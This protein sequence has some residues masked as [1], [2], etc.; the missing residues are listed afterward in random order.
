MNTKPI[1]HHLKI[2]LLH[3]NGDIE[4]VPYADILYITYDKPYTTFCYMENRKERKCVLELSLTYL[5]QNLPEIFFR[6][7]PGVILNLCH[8]RKHKHVEKVIVM[9]NGKEF[10]MSR[11]KSHVF[12]SKKEQLPRLSPLCE[13]C[14][15]CIHAC[16]VRDTFCSQAKK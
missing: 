13:P 6:C 10:E 8:F 2:E 5:E 14:L 3:K 12:R 15:V 4:L 11:R 16:Q 9:E 7:N 1:F